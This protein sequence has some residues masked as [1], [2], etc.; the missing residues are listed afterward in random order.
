MKLFV[1]KKETPL[2]KRALRSYLKRTQS[3][4]NHDRIACLLER[5]ELC[6]QL[7]DNKERARTDELGFTLEESIIDTE[8]TDDE[9]Y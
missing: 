5:I 8:V 9:S 6:E 3:T 7:Q 2:L 1:N 4:E